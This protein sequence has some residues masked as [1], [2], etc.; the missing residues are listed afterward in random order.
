MKSIR[1]LTCLMIIALPQV[2]YADTTSESEPESDI[3]ADLP[4]GKDTRER[5][6]T[7]RCEGKDS[8]VEIAVNALC[9][10]HSGVKQTVLE[11]VSQHEDGLAK[12]QVA[13]FEKRLKYTLHKHDAEPE[14][15]LFES[16]GSQ[17]KLRAIAI[18]N[19]DHSSIDSLQLVIKPAKGKRCEKTVDV[20][21]VWGSFP[22]RAAA[23]QPESAD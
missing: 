13:L 2:T 22:H 8:W 6:D 14:F 7:L 4:C 18:T 10:T 19:E 3:V 16:N 20:S 1:W 21:H 11:V 15:A 17:G 23:Q 9:G 12:Q 5:V